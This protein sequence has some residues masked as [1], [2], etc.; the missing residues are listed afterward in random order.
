MTP[1]RLFGCVGNGINATV[2]DAHRPSSFDEGWGM[3]AR[4]V[5]VG[6]GPG[7]AEYLSLGALDALRR[8][9]LVLGRPSHHPAVSELGGLG[10]SFESLD[11]VYETSG[12]MPEVYARLADEVLSAASKNDGTIAYAVPGHPLVAEAS[13]GNLLAQARG[14]GVE[15]EVIASVSAVELCLLRL[16][17]DPLRGVRVADAQAVPRLDPATAT[18]F[19]QLD[20]RMLASDLKLSLLE[21]YPSEHEVT[22]LHAVGDPEQEWLAR[23]PL[24]E[25]DRRDDFDHLTSLFVPPLPEAQRPVLLQD[26]VDIMARLRSPGGCPWDLEQTH[27]SLKPCLEEEAQEVLEAIDAQ[28]PPHLCEEL[29]DVLLQVLFHAQLASEVGDFDIRDILKGLRDKLIERHPHVFGEVKI[30]T[31]AEVLVAWDQIK[32]RARVARLSDSEAGETNID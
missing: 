22:L 19:M 31:A 12:N 3:P 14:R 6:L 24:S 23:V 17:F 9:A 7:R 10:V 4:I 30:A 16:G 27:E 11:W 2:Q 32:R 28:D 25:M 20:Q 21:I 5:V 29:G 15:V 1:A 26:L 18:L 13:V 8:A